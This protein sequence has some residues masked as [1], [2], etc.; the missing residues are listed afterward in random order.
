MK[1]HCKEPY[2]SVQWLAISFSTNI[3]T[4]C[5]LLYGLAATPTEALVALFSMLRSSLSVIFYFYLISHVRVMVP[6][7]KKVIN[8]TL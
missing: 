8:L 1:L 3:Q 5:T 4:F 2:I 6:Y 7:P